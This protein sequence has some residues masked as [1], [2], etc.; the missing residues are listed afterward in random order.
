MNFLPNELIIESLLKIEN[1]KDLFTICQVSK[2]IYNMCKS[3]VIAKQIMKKLVKFDKP[4]VFK[5][6]SGFFK[7]YSQT[8]KVLHPDNLQNFYKNILPEIL[9]NK[10]KKYIDQFNKKF[11]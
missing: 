11:I 9:K 1:V 8:S 6:Y 2:K 10:D 3:E 5:S 7:H 4:T